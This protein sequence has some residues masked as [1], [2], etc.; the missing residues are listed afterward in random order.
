MK[1]VEIKIRRFKDL[2]KGILLGSGAKWSLIRV[3]VVDY[4]LDGYQFTN[5]K[6]V[7]YENKIIISEKILR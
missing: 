5:N 7:V 6:Y 2:V 3:N 4:V 1:I